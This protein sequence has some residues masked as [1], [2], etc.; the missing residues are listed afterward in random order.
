MGDILDIIE[1]LTLT[2]FAPCELAYYRNVKET[3]GKNY[4]P[5]LLQLD[6]VQTRHK[7]ALPVTQ[8]VLK[9][10][11]TIPGTMFQF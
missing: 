3:S 11:K 7:F 4:T 2:I 5:D 1:A 8:T 9:E 6:I 10:K